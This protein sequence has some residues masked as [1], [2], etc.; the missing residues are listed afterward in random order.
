MGHV[1]LPGLAKELERDI[2]MGV[3]I[4]CPV[5]G[6]LVPTAFADRASKEEYDAADRFGLEYGCRKIV[7]V[8]GNGAP[9][10]GLGGG[11]GG[12]SCDEDATQESLAPQGGT[13]P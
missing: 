1:E 8:I 7:L 5:N 13:V 4:D 3:K 2:V 11:L 9:N 6:E 10:A 12:V